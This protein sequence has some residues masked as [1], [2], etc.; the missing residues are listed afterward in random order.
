MRVL[1][2][3]FPPFEGCPVNPSQHLIQ[4]LARLPA[5]P[6]QAEIITA[7]VPVDYVGL[8][9]V[10][11]Q[12]LS[13]VKPQVWIAFGVGRQETPLRLELRGVNRD[14]SDRPDN[15]GIVRKD[16]TISPIGPDLLET[17]L[18]LAELASLLT[19]SGFPSV[20]SWDAGTYLCN[21][22]IYRA[23]EQIKERRLDCQ[24]M[25]VHLA[26]AEIGFPVEKLL[27]SLQIM[28][29]WFQNRSCPATTADTLA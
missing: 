11:Q 13:E 7:E 10:I 4:A 21:H 1:I 28:I 14:H 16:W 2:T 6:T 3:G 9:S 5:P 23:M 18:P 24:F 19:T 12:L 15:Q 22:L 20:I 26:P 25:F 8:D 17:E 27:F 29:E